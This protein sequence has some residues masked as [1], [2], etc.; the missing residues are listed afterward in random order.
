MT[1][2]MK[3]INEIE[4]RVAFSGKEA[5]MFFI[6]VFVVSDSSRN[7]AYGKRCGFLLRVMVQRMSC[8]KAGKDKKHEV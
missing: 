4:E 5:A 3:F 7:K 2:K 6:P 8:I 1:N